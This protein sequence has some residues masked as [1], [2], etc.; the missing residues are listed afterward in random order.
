VLTPGSVWQ[1]KTVK[2]YISHNCNW[3][4]NISRALL[5][6]LL[7]AALTTCKK[8]QQLEQVFQQRP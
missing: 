3:R 5:L 4:A 2:K 8:E 7:L 6:L 1:N